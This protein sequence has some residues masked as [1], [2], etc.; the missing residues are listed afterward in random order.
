M[1]KF[2]EIKKKYEGFFVG[3]DNKGVTSTAA[4]HIC[5][6]G[7]ELLKIEQSKLD[8]VNFV[9]VNAG[10]LDSDK[11]RRIK[12]GI[13][14]NDLNDIRE[15]INKIAE[16]HAMVAWLKEA[17]NAK[18]SICKDVS[19]LSMD[20]FY[21][22]LNVEVPSYTKMENSL[23]EKDVLATWSPAKRA[24]YYRLGAYCSLIGKFIHPNGQF[25]EA[26]KEL[27]KISKEPSI[28]DG[29]G[30]DAIVY[31][32]LG[33]IDRET[34]K[35][36]YN[37]YADLL[38]SNEAELN[39][40]KAEIEDTIKTDTIQKNREFEIAYAEYVNQSDFYK[41]K[42]KAWISDMESQAKNLKIYIPDSIIDIYKRISN[43]NI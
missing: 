17:I 25:Y 2:E 37:W 40:M 42:Y 34:V 38:R 11:S 10:L 32:Y 39:K 15:S 41:T 22:C 21:E 30:R 29:N 6:K 18:N 43:G 27:D 1:S 28:V 14:E 16:L 3:S 24:K 26:K 5:N 8:S 31:D 35:S 9:T 20:D 36:E 13:S 4:A 23:E 33:S 19:N 7:K 12:T